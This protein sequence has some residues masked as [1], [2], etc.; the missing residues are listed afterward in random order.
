[1]QLADAGKMQISVEWCSYYSSSMMRQWFPREIRRWLRP[2]NF[3]RNNLNTALKLSET[4]SPAVRNCPRPFL[5]C[6]SYRAQNPSSPFNRPN[7]V[8]PPCIKLLSAPFTSVPPYL[9]AT[10]SQSS[11][12]ATKE[13][14]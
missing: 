11:P 13:V 5:L 6:I 12:P 8:A 7:I 2:W 10:M 1:M 14:W 4:E 9:D 3:I